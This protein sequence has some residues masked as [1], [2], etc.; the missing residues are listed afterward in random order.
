MQVGART[1]KKSQR[2]LSAIGRNFGE[3]LGFDSRTAATRKKRDRGLKKVC[4][5][6]SKYKSRRGG[7]NIELQNSPH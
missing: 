1:I 5:F 3:K 6:C 7:F 4:L 2:F